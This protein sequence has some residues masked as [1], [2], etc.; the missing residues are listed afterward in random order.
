LLEPCGEIG[1]IP[2]RHV[3]HA[4]VVADLAHHHEAGV[5]ADAHL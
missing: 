4:Q 1:G 5:N 3:V 2:H